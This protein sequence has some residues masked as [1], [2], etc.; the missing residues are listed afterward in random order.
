[1]GM[2]G[3]SMVLICGA[4]DGTEATSEEKDERIVSDTQQLRRKLVG[5]LVLL[6]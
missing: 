3:G 1:M 4:W 6:Y 5:W 2:H